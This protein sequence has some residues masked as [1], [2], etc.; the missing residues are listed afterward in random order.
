[1]IRVNP[2]G[3]TGSQPDQGPLFQVGEKALLDTP[4]MNVTSDL[5]IALSKGVRK[6]WKEPTKLAF[7]QAPIEPAACYVRTLR[8]RAS[9]W[10]C[11]RAQLE[12]KLKSTAN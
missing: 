3:R 11:T 5:P 6:S 1:M 9:H 2:G 4:G 7:P 12:V 10:Q 8:R